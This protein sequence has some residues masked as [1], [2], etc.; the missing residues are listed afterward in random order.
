DPSAADK[1]TIDT[2]ISGKKIKV[3]IYNSQ[4]STPDVSEQVSAARKAGIPVAQITETLSPA[5]ATFQQWQVTQLRSLERALAQ[6]SG[7]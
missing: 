6:A 7:T 3:Y 5:G 1:A 2:Q 4:N